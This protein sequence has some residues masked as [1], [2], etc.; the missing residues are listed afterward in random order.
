MKKIIFLLVMVVL[1]GFVFAGTSY[2]PWDSG[3]NTVVRSPLLAEY[4]TYEG[5]VTKPTVLVM[6]VKP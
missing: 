4:F 1:A 3:D 2:P 6:S 5:I